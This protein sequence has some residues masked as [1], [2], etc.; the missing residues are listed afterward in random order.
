MAEVRGVTFEEVKELRQM[1]F[2]LKSKYEV[3]KELRAQAVR[4]TSI[5]DGLPKSPNSGSGIAAPVINIVMLEEELKGLIERYTRKYGEAKE[6]LAKIEAPKERSIMELRYLAGKS[7]SEIAT[8]MSYSRARVLQLHKKIL[9][10]L[11]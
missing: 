6:E 8:I 11:Y 7:W 9:K 4:I 10:R 2:E 3:L 1:H 5:L